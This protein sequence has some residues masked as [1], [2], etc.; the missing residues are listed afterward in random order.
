MQ[1]A[2]CG[3][4]NPSGAKF[5][6]ECGGSLKRVCAGCSAQLPPTAKFCHECGRRTLVA[7]APPPRASAQAAAPESMAGGRYRIQRFLGEG[8][9]KRV[10]LAHDERLARDVA[11]ALVKA[12]G[13][14]EAGRVRVRREAQAMA[15][16]G[17]HPN[18]VTVHDIG[19]E[20]GQL[21]IVSQYMAGGDLEHG[22]EGAGSRLP[23]GM[24]PALLTRMS[25][26][27]PA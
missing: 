23:P 17:D 21:Y 20:D 7:E 12:E 27:G 22:L 10:Y 2:S 5:C 26:S 9:K 6:H 4:T 1:C 14:D 19:E 16:L 8:A 18:I 24:A 13:L 11:L 15:H 25:V 3:H